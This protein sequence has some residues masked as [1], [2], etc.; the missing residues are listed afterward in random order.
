M[1]NDAAS[2]R[3][4]MTWLRALSIALAVL[5]LLCTSTDIASAQRRRGRSRG[6]RVRV[7]VVDIGGN[8][9]YLSSGES[10]GVGHGSH[11][12]IARRTYAVVASTSSWSAID[13]GGR[14]IPLGTVGAATR[15]LNTE[16]ESR[17][18]RLG[19]PRPL[20]AFQGQWPNATVPASEQRPDPVPLGRNIARSHR[21]DLAFTAS[22][23]AI[24]PMEGSDGDTLVRGQIRARAKIA[25]FD[26]LPIWI[27]AD[28]AGQFWWADDIDQ[29]RGG[30]SRPPLRVR[31][32][33]FAWGQPNETND[34]YGSVGRLRHVAMQLG[35]LDGVS[36][37]S[38]SIDGFTIGG[39]GGVVPDPQDGIPDFETQRFGLEFAYRDPSSEWRPTLG[40]VTHGSVYKG[41]LDERRINA[42]VQLFPGNARLGAH[43]EISLHD[44]DN[45]WNV[46]VVELSAAGI[47]GGIR[48]D[49]LDI[50]ARFDQRRPERS[51]WLASQLP[52]TW[53]CIPTPQAVGGGSLNERCSGADDSRLYGSID[54]GL[55][56]SDIAFRAGGQMIH[57]V[58]DRELSQIGG[59]ASARLP[60]F[61]ERLRADVLLSGLAGTVYDSVAGRLGIGAV[62]VPDVLDVS[63]HYRVGFNYYRAETADWLEHL[64]GASLLFTPMS[65]LA[66]SLT[67]EGVS[68]RDL[69]VMFVRL[70]I[71]Y[72]PQ[73]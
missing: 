18:Q 71:G 37:R 42:L 35:M 31:E 28:A 10:E 43:T 62:L 40:L 36:V 67:G 17:A 4:I 12:R 49:D 50:S 15:M 59:Y 72:R 46:G 55:N 11:V 3:T 9:A 60:R 68:G 20:T 25:P 54:A 44:P 33:N 39:F 51:L 65:E 5:C 66:F 47:D 63:A 34:F 48:I 61:L 52:G 73:I 21:V 13:I 6:G 14:D 27:N 38:P 41:N 26:N 64:A 69:N 8:R 45:Q 19:D 56:L 24:V 58:A 1:R 29:R 57:Y 53:L 32:L 16:E 70:D 7:T 23:A 2:S 30:S 22:T